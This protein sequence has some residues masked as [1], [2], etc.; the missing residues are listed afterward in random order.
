MPR[1]TLLLL[2]AVLTANQP[3]AQG[4]ARSA[5]ETALGSAPGPF[6]ALSVADLDRQ[7]AW[8]RDT[9]GFVIH[10]QGT[11]PNRP[12]RFAL[13]RQ[14]SAYL[15]LLQLP[16]AK[17]RAEVA[18]RAIE[19]HQIHGFFK[20]GFIVKDIDAAHRRIKDRGVP[21]AYELGSAPDSP[22]RSFGI[23]DPE[24]NLLQFFGE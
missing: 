20:S 24:G 18:G 8:Y 2:L 19:S 16:D 4:P 22:Y 10:R 1:L 17:P 14:D 23:R 7:V 13:L 15:E 9:L 12:V 5:G 3:L 6:L 21:L 11:A